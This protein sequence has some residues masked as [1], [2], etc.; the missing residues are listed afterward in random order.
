MSEA[1]MKSPARWLFALS[2]LAVAPAAFAY[3][4]PGAGL[5]VLGALLAIIAGIGATIL[6]L[7]LLPFRMIKQRRKA[8][9]QKAQQESPKAGD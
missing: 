4:G 8:A 2:A 3:V 7:V 1:R 5:G 9:A 6:G